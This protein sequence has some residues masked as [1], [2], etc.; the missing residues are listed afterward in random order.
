MLYI[1]WSVG[2]I[3]YGSLGIEGSPLA[4]LGGGW[5]NAGFVKGKGAEYVRRTGLI[6]AAPL[7]ATAAIEADISQ[8][9]SENNCSN[10][11]LSEWN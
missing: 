4:W 5:K 9:Q 3:G 2:G 11:V 1:S 7:A 8:L 6:L 10:E